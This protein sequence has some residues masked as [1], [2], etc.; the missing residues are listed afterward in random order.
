MSDIA[1][2]LADMGDDLVAGHASNYLIRMVRGLPR[3]VDDIERD[4]G[5]GTYLKMQ[6]DPIVGSSIDYLKD[7]VLAEGFSFLP[8]HESDAT[9][10][11][12]EADKIAKSESLKE[13]FESMVEA[14]ET[15]FL[16]TLEGLLDAVAFGYSAA[17]IN[18]DL[19]TEGPYIGKLIATDVAVKPRENVLFVVNGSNRVLGFL[20]NKAGDLFPQ[21]DLED[22]LNSS[23]FITKSKFIWVSNRM[24]FG[25]PRGRSDLRRAYSDWEFKNRSKVE[26]FKH[27]MLHGSG[28]L[29][30]LLKI[31][32][33]A[34]ASRLTYDTNADGTIKMKGGQKVEISRVSA[35]T[36]T[37][38]GSKNASVGAI[39]ADEL[40]QVE[41]KSN[42]EAFIAAESAANRNMTIAILGASRATQ[43]AQH[44]SKAD[45]ETAMDVVRSK[46]RRLK[47]YLCLAIDEHF[48]KPI[49]LANWGPTWLEYRPKISLGAFQFADLREAAEFAKTIGYTID[50]S[51]LQVVDKMIGLPPRDVNAIDFRDAQRREEERLAI[52]QNRARDLRGQINQNQ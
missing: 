25:D 24:I 30:A 1:S 33:G 43:E 8:R 44:G 32:P 22:P 48:I 31:V 47:Q 28:K 46:A 4:F 51:Q 29:I 23:N 36:K 15:P 9:P 7:L 16:Y 18:F 40:V 5:V 52:Q 17:E 2:P 21:A 38:A 14:F 41:A 3:H 11:P 19:A 13:F 26:W 34:E 6:N 49:V 37:L 12:D 27:L 20:I 42:G 50:E 10:T 35:I 45:S 39:E